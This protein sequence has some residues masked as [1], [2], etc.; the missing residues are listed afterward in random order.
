MAVV[1]KKSENFHGIKIAVSKCPQFQNGH[2]KT[3]TSEA[4]VPIMEPKVELLGRLGE[5]QLTPRPPGSCFLL[6][7]TLAQ[8]TGADSASTSRMQGITN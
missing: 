4:H 5:G 2:I 1:F 6:R 3:T 7:R 8:H